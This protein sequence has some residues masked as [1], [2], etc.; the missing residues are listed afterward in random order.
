MN[1]LLGWGKRQPHKMVKH[2]QTIRRQQP[3]SCLNVF[4]HFWG[5]ALKRLNKLLWKAPQGYQKK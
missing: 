2:S 4:D 3:T 5:L 1:P